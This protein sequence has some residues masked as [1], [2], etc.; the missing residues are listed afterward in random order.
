MSAG[1]KIGV[2]V[3]VG[4]G[5][6]IIVVA[7]AFWLFR[8]RQNKQQKTLADAPSSYGGSPTAPSELG[9]GSLGASASYQRPGYGT[10]SE[11]GSEPAGSTSK[12]AQTTPSELYAA[13]PG[14]KFVHELGA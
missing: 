1:A 14:P 3:G 11:L 6:F 10:P 9:V 7:L 4:V 8:R 2:G 5:G 12:N 13:P